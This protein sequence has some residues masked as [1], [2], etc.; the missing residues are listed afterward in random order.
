MYSI[1]FSNSEETSYSKSDWDY[2][3]NI[4][5]TTYNF[6]ADETYVITIPNGFDG[7]VFYIERNGSTEVN[8][9]NNYTIEETE[10]YIL[11]EEHGADYYIF[12]RLSDIINN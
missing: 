6:K 12:Y 3:G 4:A 9:E 5:F 7:A 10:E 1:G 11:D 2:N 8:S